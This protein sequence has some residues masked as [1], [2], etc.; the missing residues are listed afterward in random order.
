[1]KTEVVRRG[2]FL[3][4]EGENCCHEMGDTLTLQPGRSSR[5]RWLR[6]RRG[7]RGFVG[8][9]SQNFLGA[10]GRVSK[11]SRY[12]VWRIFALPLVPTRTLSLFPC[13]LS[14]L[15]FCC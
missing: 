10:S 9:P 5:I 14:F 8:E 2:I 12:T 11:V 15:L 7:H 4:N 13:R 1:M 6:E 3:S